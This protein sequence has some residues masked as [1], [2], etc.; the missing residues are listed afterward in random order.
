MTVING[1]A[2]TSVL[3]IIAQTL[4]LRKKIGRV[5]RSNGLPIYDG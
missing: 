3:Y 5:R 1:L 4:L 2:R